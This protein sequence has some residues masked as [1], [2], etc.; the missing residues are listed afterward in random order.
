MPIRPGAIS[1]LC[2]RMQ[3][4]GEDRGT[5]KRLLVVAF[6]LFPFFCSHAEEH[7]VFY[8]FGTKDQ[9]VWNQLGKYFVTKGYRVSFYDGADNLERHVENVNRINRL[10]ASLLIAMDYNIGDKNRL[11]VAVTTAKKGKGNILAIDEVPAAHGAESRE[12]ASLV[13]GVFKTNVK[14]LPLFPL[15]GVDMPGIFLGVE[16]TPDRST[17]IFD[18]LHESLQKYFKRGRKDER[19]RKGQ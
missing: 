2:T 14:E 19:Q 6:L 3:R 16:S 4:S 13:A 8:R 9:I 5:V 11:M 1:N 15:L 7:V 17:E 12:L 18:K 10:N